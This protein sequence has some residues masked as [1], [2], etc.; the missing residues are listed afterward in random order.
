MPILSE[1]M[2]RDHPSLHVDVRAVDVGYFNVKF[3]TGPLSN[4]RTW[5]VGAGS[6]PS[7]A[8]RLDS[9]A[10]RKQFSGLENH[11]GF[12]VE[13]DRQEY[14]VG[15][16]AALNS[17]GLD[18]RSVAEDYS[19]SPKYLALLR[20]ALAHMADHAGVTDLTIEHL[21]VALPLHTFAA[22]RERLTA[23]ATGEH[24]IGPKGGPFRR[25][26]VNNAHVIVQPHGTL[27][28]YGVN[29]NGRLEGLAIVLDIGG[30]T[31]D[32][33]VAS[34]VKSSWSRSGAYPKAMLA[35]SYAILDQIEPGLRDQ[36]QIVERVDKAIRDGG[37]HFTIRG[38]DY[39]FANMCPLRSGHAGQ[40][41]FK[42]IRWLRARVAATRTSL[43]LF[44]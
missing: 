26:T 31:L 21:V 39:P 44:E 25:V 28:D 12:V 5:P 17:T 27:L 34:K 29:M 8:P 42:M 36:F 22:Y 20:G 30:G 14:F 24:L 1:T 6:F 23:R 4:D 16:D 3:T 9:P 13:V 10:M 38:R 32:W 7:L 41:G 33:Y 37:G 11:K 43:R 19:C 2:K 18:P 35:C 15:E 40:F